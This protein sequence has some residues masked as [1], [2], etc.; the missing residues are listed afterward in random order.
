[1]KQIPDE[2]VDV[3]RGLQ[4]CRLQLVLLCLQLRR[5]LPLKRQAKLFYVHLKTTCKVL[6]PEFEVPESLSRFLARQELGVA[7]CQLVE[8]VHEA[9]HMAQLKLWLRPR[10]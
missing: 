4:G 1:M 10:L 3:G 5:L 8:A 6:Q 7:F 9:L 2:S